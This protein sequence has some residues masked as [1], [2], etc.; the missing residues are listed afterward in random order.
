MRVETLAKR[1]IRFTAVREMV[2]MLRS[3]SKPT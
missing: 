1:R 3:H 2:C